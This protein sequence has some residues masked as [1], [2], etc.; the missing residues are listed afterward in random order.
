MQNFIFCNNLAWKGC[1]DTKKL[2]EASKYF[3]SQNKLVSKDQSVRN[4]RTIIFCTIL[5]WDLL[6]WGCCSVSQE[7]E[8]SERML[9]PMSSRISLCSKFSS[10]SSSLSRVTLFLS[11]RL[12]VPA[13]SMQE[14]SPRNPDLF[15]KQPRYLVTLQLFST[16][17]PF[18]PLRHFNIVT[19]CCSASGRSWGITFQWLDSRSSSAFHYFN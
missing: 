11:F 5:T 7:F 10:L 13:F 12:L 9:S 16:T 2:R 8:L 19:T 15:L 1:F 18:R 14:S 3:N 6:L 17:I 4:R